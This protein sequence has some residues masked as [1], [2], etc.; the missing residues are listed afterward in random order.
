MF[1]KLTLKLAVVAASL[2]L[3]LTGQAGAAD[4]LKGTIEIDGSSTVYPITEAVAEEFGKVHK[5]VRVTVGISGTGGGFKRFCNGEIPIADASRPITDAEK[6]A[7]K[8]KGITYTDI[9]VAY[10]GVTIAI[11][12][13]NTWAQKLTTAELKSIFK[14]GST[15]KKWSDV[16]KGFPNEEIKIYSPGSDSGTFDFFTEKVNGKSKSSRNDSQITFSEDDN[17]LVEGITNDKY[18]IGYFGYAYYVENKAKLKAVVVD[19]GKRAVGPS[20]QTIAKGMYFLSRPIFFYVNKADLA[21]RAE[22]KAFSQFYLENAGKLS[23]EVGYI[24][25]SKGFYT[26]QA[27][28]LK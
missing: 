15:V 26:S 19:N 7:C 2:S 16:R 11:N 17:V 8:A 24:P 22:V 12:K 20:A 23:K 21:N 25:L 18:A 4:N 5:D 3:L 6:T 10:D 28:K 9:T 1:K 13:N 27:S 14:S